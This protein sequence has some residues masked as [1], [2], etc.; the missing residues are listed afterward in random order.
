MS[1]DYVYSVRMR[2]STGGR[3]EDG[4]RHVSGAE[5]LVE[6]AGIDDVA[7]AL[8]RRARER[9]E[10]PDFVQITVDRIERSAVDTATVLPLLLTEPMPARDAQVAASIRLREAGVSDDAIDRGFE[11]LSEGIEGHLL[12]PFPWRGEGLGESGIRR[13]APG[14]M[15]LDAST[16]V[17]I[18][19]DP[20][21]GVRAT[22]FDYHPAHIAS[23]ESALVDAGLGHF[24]TR[25]ALALA[26]KVMWSGVLAELC[27]SD[28]PGYTAGYLATASRYVRFA[29]FKP[30][31]AAGGRAFFVDRAKVDVAEVIDRLEC[32]ALWIAGPLTIQR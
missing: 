26:T 4:G 9:A 6:E 14:A 15:L 20:R 22:R 8:M 24:R 31:G 13:S 32:R 18:T 11:L 1:A 16:G 25:E 19:P 23:I 5:R 10:A 3:H 12:P 27:W 28:D 29:D 7:A 2:A 30:D 17:N 21:R